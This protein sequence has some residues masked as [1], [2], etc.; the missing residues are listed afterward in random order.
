MAEFKVIEEGAFG[1]YDFQA[2]AGTLEELF[3]ICA[4]ATFDAMTDVRKIQLIDEVEFEENAD[5]LEDLLYAFL[6]ELIYIKDAEKLFFGKFD[7]EINEGF[8]LK[9][10]AY[11]EHI[12]N[13]KHELKTDVKAVTYH[14][15]KVEKMGS[16]YSAHVILDL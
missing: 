13:D 8:N 7:I 6:A 15:L 2:S 1:D 9:C 12:N 14:H 11:G 10:K 4:A 5:N 3:A 16:G